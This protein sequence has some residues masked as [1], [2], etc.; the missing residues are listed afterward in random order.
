MYFS[1]L[2]QRKIALSELSQVVFLVAV[3]IGE[4]IKPFLS[5]GD[6]LT[7][8]WPNDLLL[9]GAKCG[10]ILLESVIMPG[11]DSASCLV[12]SVGLNVLRAP[13]ISTA[14]KLWSSPEA[15]PP[16]DQ[17]LSACV[18]SFD[19]WY[20]LWRYMGFGVVREHWRKDAAHLGM[21][22]T[23]HEGNERISG[24]FSDIDAEGSLLLEM[25]G[26]TP[27][28]IITGEIFGQQR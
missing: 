14:T 22:I 21:A 2:L 26:G 27:R 3:A 7:Y 20:K 28:R 18:E 25:E 12:V 13:E 11:S 15:A 16:L 19:Y 1:F 23:W 17:L 4:A 9:N 8:K 5:Q 10:G 24:I 6:K